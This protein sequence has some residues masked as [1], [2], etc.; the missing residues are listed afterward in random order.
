[1]VN[2]DRVGKNA[3]K[4]QIRHKHIE[5]VW[6]VKLMAELLPCQ[7]EIFIA[8]GYINNPDCCIFAYNWLWK[9]LYDIL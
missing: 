3:V 4:F 8:L 7:F 5:N 1:M 2:C 6:N 9:C